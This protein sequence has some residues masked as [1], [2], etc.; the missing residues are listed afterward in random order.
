MTRRIADYP[1]AAGSEVIS[2]LRKLARPLEG[3]TVA[4]VSSTRLAAGRGDLTWMVPL[5]NDLGMRARG[6]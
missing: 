3:R 1:L 6:T 4:H 2:Q 5:M